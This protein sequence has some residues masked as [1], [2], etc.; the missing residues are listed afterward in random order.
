ME[1]LSLKALAGRVL[2][3]NRQRSAAQAAA[4]GA[5]GH[6]ALPKT[7]GTA[8]EAGIRTDRNAYEAFCPNYGK[9]CSE[10]PEF[11]VLSLLFCRKYNRAHAAEIPDGEIDPVT[12]R[13]LSCFQPTEEDLRHCRSCPHWRRTGKG[14]GYCGVHQDGSKPVAESWT[15]GYI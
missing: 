12:G 9:G 2:E 7:E 4:A 13:G 14:T 1:R 5:D 10:C 8:G 3:R 15:N 6:R 11:D